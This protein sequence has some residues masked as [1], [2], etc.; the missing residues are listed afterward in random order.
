MKKKEIAPGKC[1]IR[2]AKTELFK[3][4]GYFES[5]V[6]N[7]IPLEIFRH[8]RANNMLKSPAL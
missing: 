4:K 7:K 6:V 3:E 5:G 2:L 8:P 1:F